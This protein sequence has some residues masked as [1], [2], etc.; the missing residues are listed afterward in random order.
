M[1]GMAI[2]EHQFR[3]SARHAGIVVDQELER[4]LQTHCLTHGPDF[5]TRC[6]SFAC[7]LIII[8]HMVLLDRRVHVEFEFQ[9]R[10][11]S[12]HDAVI[13]ELIFITRSEM[14]AHT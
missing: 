2:K 13:D 14:T 7:T 8:D 9:S 3:E 4:A 12:T 5:R 6:Y 11:T 1:A 10:V